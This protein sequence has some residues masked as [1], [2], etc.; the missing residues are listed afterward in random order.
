M[1]SVPAGRAVLA[2]ISDLASKG[3]LKIDTRGF[4]QLVDFLQSF[5]DFYTMS[6]EP[7]RLVMENLL[8]AF[9]SALEEEDDRVKKAEIKTFFAF[10]WNRIYLSSLRHGLVLKQKTLESICRLEPII[11][12]LF[13]SSNIN[14]C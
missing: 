9:M 1:K 3:K 12:S 14:K 8:E 10:A 5:P 6:L 13:S 7:G 4:S 11:Y 2:A